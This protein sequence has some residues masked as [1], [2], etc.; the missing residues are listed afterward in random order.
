MREVDDHAFFEP[1]A[2]VDGGPGPWLG[3]SCAS[4][5][6]EVFGRGPLLVAL[7]DNGASV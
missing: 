6:F 2:I 4:E 3:V 7:R 1:R 5:A